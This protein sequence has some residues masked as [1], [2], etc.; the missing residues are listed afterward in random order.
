[1]IKRGKF[2]VTKC[3]RFPNLFFLFCIINIQSQSYLQ[4]L[5][6]FEFGVHDQDVLFLRLGL[7]LD[8][9]VTGAAD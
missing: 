4:D 7:C 1:M 3:S 9:V 6:D 5:N 8:C 2:S